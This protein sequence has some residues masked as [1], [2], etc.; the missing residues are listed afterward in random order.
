MK[1]DCSE[2][3]GIEVSTVE[4]FEQMKLFFNKQVDKGIFEEI[5]VTKPHYT[6]INLKGQKV[7]WFADKW[8]RCKCCGVIWEFDY[9]DFPACGFVK[10]L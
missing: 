5:K 4:L 9:P 7:E 8:Y 2:R 1:C 10:K 6:A 3:I